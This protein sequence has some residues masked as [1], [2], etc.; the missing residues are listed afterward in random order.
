M[1]IKRTLA[2]VI[3]AIMVLAALPAM[4]ITTMAASD[5]PGIWDTF[6]AATDYREGTN[7]ETGE[8]YTYKPAAGY[9]YTEEGLVNVPANYENTTVFT[10]TQTKE[11]QNLQDGVYMQFRVD[12]FSYGGE[13]GKADQWIAVTLWDAQQPSPSSKKSG[14]GWVALMRMPGNGATGGVTGWNEIAKSEENPEGAWGGTG[15]MQ[16]TPVMKNDKETYTF[17]VTYSVANGYDVKFNGASIPGSETISNHLNSLDESGH[18]Y[19]GVTL[20]STVK[21]GKGAVSILKYGTSASDATVPEGSDSKPAEEN[22]NVPAAEIADQSTIE[23]NMPAYFFDASNTSDPGAHHCEITPQGDN[24]FHVVGNEGMSSVFMTASVPRTVS[25][26]AEDFPIVAIL[27]RNYMPEGGTIWYSAGDVMIGNNDY[28]AQWSWYD[29]LMFGENMEYALATVDLTDCWE[30]RI[31]GL[32]IDFNGMIYEGDNVFD[33]CYIGFF[34]SVD[35]AVAYNATRLE[36]MGVSSVPVTEPSY[37][38]VTDPNEDETNGETNANTGD[39]SGETQPIEGDDKGCA[40]VM[41]A[42][43]AALILSAAMAAVVLKKKD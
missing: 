29:G 38:E 31:N 13:T 10:T 42:G 23:E 6:R 16:V 12:E 4:T 18:F 30:G 32:R 22:I 20:Y 27:T 40:S 2:L 33:V 39:A 28:T 41:G 8:P 36:A 19:V 1:K 21:G 15:E 11:K 43:S 25:Y 37:E 34:R 26:A 35:E 3:A 24:S 17:E 14:S 5:T 9:M 7:P